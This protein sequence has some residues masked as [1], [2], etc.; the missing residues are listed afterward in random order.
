MV[1]RMWRVVRRGECT[2]TLSGEL[3]LPFTTKKREGEEN[4][5]PLP[6]RVRLV[7]EQSRCRLEI[8]ITN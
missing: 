2:C 6:G 1:C 3:R 7:V 8:V 4:R 5:P